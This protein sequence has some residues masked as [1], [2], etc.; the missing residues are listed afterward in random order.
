SDESSNPS[1]IFSSSLQ[2]RTTR[3]QSRVE[4]LPL[5]SLS[6][7]IRERQEMKRCASS[8]SDISRLKNATAFPYLEATLSAMLQTS[9]DL[10]SDGRAAMTIRLPGWKPPNFASRSRKPDGVPV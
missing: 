3:G 6:L 4:T 7:G 1:G 8:A 9:A 2:A 5:R 10:P